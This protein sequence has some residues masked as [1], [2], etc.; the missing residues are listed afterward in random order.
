MDTNFSLHPAIIE[1]KGMTCD[2][3]A[4]HVMS[5][6]E[7]AGA[8]E[9]S[10]AWRDGKA[11]FIWPDGVLE[12]D[13]RAAITEAGYRPGKLHLVGS[14]EQMEPRKD[15]DFDFVVIGAGSA[16]FAAA[17]KATEA[18]YSVALVEQ[19]LLG[20][21]CVN[22]GCVPSK[23]LLK[24]GELAW[25]VG[26]HP[27]SGITATL[28]SID[29]ATLVAQKDELVG[30]LR[31]MKYAD[32]VEDYG[33]S[34]LS[35]HARFISP[36]AIEVA[37]RTL[38]ASVF[39]VATGASTVVPPIPG[40]AEAGYLTST[41]ALEL[42]EVPKRLVVIGANAIGLE[43]GQFF[44]HLGAEVTFVDVASRIAPFEEPEVSNAL[45]EVLRAQ[46]ATIHT[47]AQVIAVD[48]SEGQVR[49]ALRV[50]GRQFD[51]ITDDILVATGRRP[52]TRDLGLEAAGV[53]VDERGAL[54]VDDE[55][56]TANPRVFGAGDV[57]GA[58]QF[59]YV[60]AYEGSLAVDNALL[61]AHQSVDF[62]GLPR[63]IF[64]SPQ[65]A[66]A[67]LTETQA[68]DAGY[69]V[70]TS[71]LPL[72]AVTRALVNRDTQGLVKLVAE[73]GTG[74]L[75]GA[76]VVADGAGDVIQSA[77]LAIRHNITTSELAATFHPYL[78]MVEALKL[79]SQTFT[80]DVRKLS[81]CAA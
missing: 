1:V 50:D 60:S 18:G 46:G 73:A 51:V 52:N 14:G 22:V 40:L 30:E 61:G 70:E 49:V 71:I 45:N 81:C 80:R 56:R 66:S 38:R 29:L 4:H 43:L 16:A 31:Q 63:V 59:V 2:D 74:R 9:V 34:V 26:H 57:T 42:T 77:V 7:N 3:C 72:S 23:A 65:V 27:F 62:T 17:I 79:A 75:L 54:V 10:V 28:G 11:N 41:T 48:R 32:L 69:E 37:G 19:N 44:L 36:D 47:D 39:L 76:S 35:G 24:A 15:T 55:L 64:T 68:R 20:G 12:E 21:T 5:A 6:L 53:D 25:A 58:P 33:F 8:R 78:T 13:L 67:G